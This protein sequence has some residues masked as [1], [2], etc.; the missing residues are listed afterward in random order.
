MFRVLRMAR[1]ESNRFPSLMG[2]LAQENKIV[3]IINASGTKCSVKDKTKFTE[4]HNISWNEP[5]IINGLNIF[6]RHQW[7]FQFY[8]YN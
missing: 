5:P 6:I 2:S 8:I 4:E 1:S 3:R 7:H